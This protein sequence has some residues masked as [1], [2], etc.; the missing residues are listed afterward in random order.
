MK[1]LLLV[2]SLVLYSFGLYAQDVRIT[3]RME[4]EPIKSILNEIEKKSDHTFIYSST[5]IDTKRNVSL[6]A[7]NEKLETVVSKLC[8]LAGFSYSFEGK[9][10]VLTQKLTPREPARGSEKTVLITGKVLDEQN[11]PLPGAYVFLKNNSNICTVSNQNGLFALNIADG[12]IN[13]DFIQVT[14]IGMK[15]SEIPLE[16]KSDLVIVLEEDTYI[17]ENVVVTGYQT[18]SK[19]RTTGSFSKPNLDAVKDRSSSMNIL[20]RLDGLVPGLMVNNSP[21]ASQNPILIRGLTTIGVEVSTGVYS[22]T[23]RNPLYVVDGLQMDDISS[24]NPQ[25]IADVTVLKD[26]TAGSIWGSRAANGVI[27]VTTKRGKANEKIRVTYDGFINFQGK[28]NLDYLPGLSS[29]QFIQAA[30]DIFDPVAYP[31]S[32]VFGGTNG[33]VPPHE[34]ILYDKYLGNITDSQANTKLDS[35]AS[36]NNL[37]QI[38]D[39]WYRNASLMNHTASLSGGSERYSFYGS[40]S[41]TNTQS[42]R[43][44]EQN[45]AYKINLR[46]DFNLNKSIRF[47]LITDLTNTITE[48]KRPMSI[49][50]RFYPYQLFQDASGNNLSIPYIQGLSEPTRLD[51]QARSRINLDYNPLD[52]FN[53][54]YTKGNAFLAR[55]TGGISLDILPGLKFEGVYGYIK[56]NTKT[57]NYDAANSYRVR[58]ELV[59]FTVASSPS[60]VP[61]YHLPT[62]GGRYA[63]DNMNSNN[64]TIRNQFT[65]DKT[66]MDKHQL[67]VLLGQEAQEQLATT[68]GS[69]VRGYNESLQTYAAINYATLGTTGVSNPVF[70]NNIG[71]SVLTNDAFNTTERQTRFTSYYTNLAYSYNKKYSMNGTFRIDQSNLFGLDKAAQNK[72]V[73]S[74]GFKWQI[75]GEEFMNKYSASIN[76]LALRA[77]YGVTGNAPTPGTAASHDIIQASSSNFLPGGV[78]SQIASPA[79]KKLTWESTNTLNIGLDFS[80]F[81][82]KLS[83]AIDIY[84]KKTTDMLGLIG[85]NTFTGYSST[86]GNLGDM[87][88]KGFE[89]SLSSLNIQK[90]NFSWTSVFVLSYNKNTITKFNTRT[91]ITTGSQKISQQFQMGYAAYAVFGYKYAHL[92]NMGDPQI[93]LADGTIT[94]ALNAAMAEDVVFMGT[95]QPV[96]NGGFSNTLR[97]KRISLSANIVYN[98]GHVMRRPVNYYY[99]GRL[100]LDNYRYIQAEFTERWKNPGDEEFTDIPSYVSS[101]VS[102]SRRN[103][104]YYASADMNVVS[105]SF[106]KLRDITLS[107]NMP[108]SIITKLKADEITFRVQ[109]SNIMLWKANKN[110]I[111]PEFMSSLPVNQNTVTLG[112]RIAF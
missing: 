103:V 57:S 30:K 12:L 89:L 44:G 45:N 100:N 50:N 65:Y 42:T 33:G 4:N 96:L 39:L 98:L 81:N 56:G 82:N 79:N 101:S 26:A 85:T 41:Y 18:L 14:F 66:L 87:D 11:K 71:R 97:Y 86:I 23:N 91:P 10:I 20:Q 28:P 19:E 31:Y 70:A 6:T 80:L 9:R 107:Y 63:I 67:T 84:S 83:G 88:N 52:E 95:S 73:W 21:T 47:Y 59:Q 72:P 55:I 15:M 32:T 110:G 34:V 92:D 25:D 102:D 49:S 29:E 43:P 74:L 48:A 5:L 76:S 16:G 93:M 105:A 61:V 8:S 2:F 37:K 7:D 36:I 22:G 1:K 108:K 24:I 46:Q 68:N 109:M 35:L 75:S 58:R 27:V 94:K 111:D 104:N 106:I 51:Y 13:K 62:T 53:Y 69:T 99:T 77:T 78:G 38:S 90:N 64:W 112:L 54:G 3:I 60:V 17:L 40:L